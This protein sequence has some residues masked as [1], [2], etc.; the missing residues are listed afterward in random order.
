MLPRPA[1]SFSSTS[2]A[3]Q[4][5]Q[6]PI[7]PLSHAVVHDAHPSAAAASSRLAPLVLLPG[8][9]G[10][11][12]NWR[13]LSKALS[14]RLGTTVAALDLRNHGESPHHPVHTYSAMAADVAAFVASQGWP[15]ANIMGHSMGGKVA[16]HLALSPGNEWIDNL[17]VVDMAPVAQT[18]TH[19]DVFK[20]YI[21]AMQRVDAAGVKSS[22]QADAILKQ[23]IPELSVRQFILTNL[24]IQP[25]GT[26]KFRVNLE[27][28]ARGLRGLWTFDFDPSVNTFDRPTLFIAGG[29]SKYVEPHMHPTIRSYFP[30]V[31]IDTIE[32]AGHW[33]HAEKP[34]AFLDSTV[35]FFL[36]EAAVHPHHHHHK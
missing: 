30:Q 6:T 3:A 15:K 27:A 11:K 35:R 17:I 25:D 20:E 14:H 21:L 26:Y 1:P 22:T 32:G 13:S 19:T 16:M 24:K 9:F 7:L 12:Q 23:S 18:A 28:L 31:R 29:N 33:V 8:L 5:Q 10:S 2:S 4:P 34:D 36:G